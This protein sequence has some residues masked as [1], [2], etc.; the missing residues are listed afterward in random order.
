MNIKLVSLDKWNF[1]VTQVTDHCFR[2]RSTVRCKVDNI[3]RSFPM[4]LSQINQHNTSD[5]QMKLSVKI[6]C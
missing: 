6:I 4:Y 2:N 1:K 5:E 3:K